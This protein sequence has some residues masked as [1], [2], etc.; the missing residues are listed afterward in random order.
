MA[1]TGLEANKQVV[2]RFYD[3]AINRQVPTACAELLTADFVHNGERRGSAGQQAVI[4]GMLAAFPDLRCTIDG[5]LAEGNEVAA[6]CT[7]TGI[8]RGAFM[9]VAPTNRAVSFQ[10]IAVLR[11]AGG[12]IAQAWENEDDIGLLKQLGASPTDGA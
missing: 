2:R 5:M 1:T 7:W 11:I 10:A 4:D 3:D 6:R 12:R 8:Q 9:G